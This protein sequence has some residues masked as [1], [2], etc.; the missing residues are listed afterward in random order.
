VIIALAFFSTFS[1]QRAASLSQYYYSS[2]STLS[3]QL[4]LEATDWYIVT[5]L[6][7]VVFV[8]FVAW[9]FASE[10]LRMVRKL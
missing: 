1:L 2:D 4:A 5:M 8:A 10:M 3:K 7:V 6:L 9:A